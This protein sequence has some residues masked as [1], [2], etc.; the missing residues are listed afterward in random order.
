MELVHHLIYKQQ[1]LKEKENKNMFKYFKKNNKNVKI[2]KGGFAILFAV[3]LASFLVTLGISIFSISLK[4]IQITTSIRDSQI[5]YYVA[6]SARECALYHDVKVEG[7]FPSSITC[8]DGLN[9][10][11]IPTVKCNGNDV[12]LVFNKNGNIY[13]SII[14][15][16]FFQASTTS[17]S[18]PVASIKITK[19]SFE[20]SIRTTIEAYGYNT[21]ILGRRVQRGIKTVNNN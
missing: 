18:T 9:C 17:S 15:D 1:F 11:I 3:L 8:S 5:A 20:N 12:N 7:S 6:D 16:P 14:K 10:N 19:E 13:E 21:S 4:E 2:S